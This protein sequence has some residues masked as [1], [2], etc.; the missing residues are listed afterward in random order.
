MMG[1]FNRSQANT[2]VI[3]E[4]HFSTETYNHVVTLELSHNSIFSTTKR[5]QEPLEIIILPNTRWAFH[6]GDRIV[7]KW[8][9][10]G[11]GGNTKRTINKS[12]NKNL[13]KPQLVVYNLHVRFHQYWL[14]LGVE[15]KLQMLR[16]KLLTE[17]RM[18]HCFSGSQ[19]FIMIVA[20]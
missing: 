20:Q 5:N 15:L 6:L 10:L 17:I 19:A 18:F 7:E 1:C 16:I 14:F 3:W 12:S 4:R 8:K 9:M 11:G 2:W 13:T